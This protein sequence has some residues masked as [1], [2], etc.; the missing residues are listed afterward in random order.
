MTH[1]DKQTTK[2]LTLCGQTDKKLI[3]L[4]GQTDTKIID[5]CGQTDTKIIGIYVD[6]E[7]QKSL[8]CMWTN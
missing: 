1:V 7:T 2:S 6:K 3:D 5:K 4:C 8:T